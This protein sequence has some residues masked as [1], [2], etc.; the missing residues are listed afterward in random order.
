[1]KDTDKVRDRTARLFALALK[2]RED[3]HEEY[4]EQLLQLANEASAH[5]DDMER[6]AASRSGNKFK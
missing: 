2:A 6:G 3:G 5:A 4:S 1:M